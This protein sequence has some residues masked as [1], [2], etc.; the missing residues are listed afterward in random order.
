[1]IVPQ[2]ANYYPALGIMSPVANSYPIIAAMPTEQER[3][4]EDI[5]R[6]H[7]SLAMVAMTYDDPRMDFAR[8]YPLVWNYLNSYYQTITCPPEL[9]HWRILV[10]QRG[11]SSP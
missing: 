11:E 2:A 7:V 8:N 4:I 1:M 6:H 5:K 10:E 3:M 9:G